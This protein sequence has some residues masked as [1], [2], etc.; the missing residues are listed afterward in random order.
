MKVKK[1]VHMQCPVPKMEH[2]VYVI[3]EQSM[4]GN[5]QTTNISQNLD[6]LNNK[7]KHQK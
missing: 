4:K 3:L 2:M 6:I 7:N 1:Q 5:I